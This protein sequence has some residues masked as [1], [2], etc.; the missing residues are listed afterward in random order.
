M[1]KA[2][3]SL[4]CVFKKSESLV[5]I[6]CSEYGYD[7]LYEMCILIDSVLH[8]HV[9]K[10]M[11]LVDN[12]TNSVQLLKGGYGWFIPFFDRYYANNLVLGNIIEVLK[13]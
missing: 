1:V 13:Y 5:D 8:D 2:E 10:D 12:I 4:L 11:V 7:Q 9:V 6:K 3:F